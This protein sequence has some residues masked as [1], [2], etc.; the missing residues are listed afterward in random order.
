[1]STTGEPRS[2]ILIIDDEPEITGLL[3]G[4]LREDYECSWANSAEEGMALLRGDKFDL[5][6][7][8][9]QMGGM[10]GL[11]LVSEVLTQSP[12]TVVIMISGLLDIETAIAAMQAGAFDYITKPFA[13]PH[14]EAAVRR[15][16]DHSRLILAKRHYENYLEELV[17]L[18]TNELKQAL[19][20]VEDAYRSTLRVLTTA[21]ETRDQDTHGHSERVAAFSLRLGREL[22][23][24]RGEMASLEY[25]ALLH[26]IGKIGVPDAILRKP[27]ELTEAEWAQMRLHPQHGKQILDGIKFLEGASRVV[28][29]H[30]EKW[31]GSG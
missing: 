18:R 8:D 23:L 13:L 16:L 9:V 7:T 26:D 5:I 3:T 27:A 30:H 15:A 14:V 10:S 24:D 28:A 29:Q 1:M 21:L 4:L 12:D 25:G 11:E 17:R 2:H 19:D 20:S 31:D 6:L 22:G